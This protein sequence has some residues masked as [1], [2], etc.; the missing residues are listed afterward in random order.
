[1]AI[2]YSVAWEAK[3]IANAYWVY[4]HQVSKQAPTGE[5]LSTGSF[6]IRG[7]KNFLPQ[8]QLVFGFALLYK[9]I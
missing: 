1:M 7:K 2:C 3:I 4:N 6:M 9:V 5:Y 8:S